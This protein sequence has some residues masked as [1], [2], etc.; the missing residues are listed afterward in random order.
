[1]R[2]VQNFPPMPLPTLALCSCPSH[3][4][5]VALKM[6][7]LSICV[8]KSALTEL[9][10]ISFVQVCDARPPAVYV[11]LPIRFP[12]TSFYPFSCVFTEAGKRA[13]NGLGDRCCRC[14]S[15]VNCAFISSFQFR[16]ACGKRIFWCAG[17][18]TVAK[19]RLWW[20]L[21][22]KFSCVPHVVLY[23]VHRRVSDRLHKAEY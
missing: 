18:S 10:Y 19:A 23:G 5:N 17:P 12:A 9:L 3:R 14:V 7:S 8:W 4:L 13:I 21:R 16:G 15:R 22:E 11:T 20:C 2:Q 6:A 1:M